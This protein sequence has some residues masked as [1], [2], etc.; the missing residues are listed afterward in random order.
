MNLRVLSLALLVAAAGLAGWTAMERFTF[1][2]GSRVWV[3]G[4]S[5]VHDWTCSA[6]QISGSLDATPAQAGLSGLSGLT[7]TVPVNALDCDNGTM[8]GKMREALGTSAIRFTASSARVG[9]ASGG[10]F[11]VEVDGQLTIH[12]TT[13]A[14]RIQAQGQDLGNGRYRFTG[15][16]PVTMSQF[17]VTPPTAM[18][19]TLRT[20]DRVTVRF[21]V[22]IAR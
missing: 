13:R 22:T 9:A 5:T 2:G 7:V 21:D 18:L 17:G 20:G 6:T 11:P 8:N 4:T 3:E 1:A 15:S 19:G 12:G 14:Q 10:R 16:V